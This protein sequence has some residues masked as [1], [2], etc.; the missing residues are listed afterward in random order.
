MTSKET[1]KRQIPSSIFIVIMKISWVKKLLNK[2]VL[3]VVKM[4]RSLL[5][6]IG[7]ETTEFFGSCIEEEG[8]EKLVLQGKIERKRERGRQWLKY[9]DGL[10]S[11]VGCKVVEVLQCAG[12]RIGFRNM[13]ADFSF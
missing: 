10:A 2:K 4:K 5:T 11:M 8:V 12:D 7:H 3:Q 1:S 9:M 6:T 13:V